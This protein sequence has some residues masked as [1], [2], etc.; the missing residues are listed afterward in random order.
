ML[1]LDRAKKIDMDNRV[2]T[3][4]TIA[5][6]V[7]LVFIYII[8]LIVTFHSNLN[9]S[10]KPEYFIRFFNIMLSFLAIISCLLCYDS[11]KKEELFIISLMYMI[12]LI[13]ILLGVFDNLTLENTII[14]MKGYIAIST[15]IMRIIII[16]IAAFP[17][18]K[19]RNFIMENKIQII[20]FIVLTALCFGYMERESIIF[21]MNKDTDFFR[22]Y[23]FLLILIYTISSFIFFRK[24][25][26]ENDYT[27]SVIG[28]SILMLWIK[29]IYAIVGSD[30][31]IMDIK[32][33]SISIT[34]MSFI[35]LIVGLFLELILTIKKNREL[36]EEIKVFYN[37]VEENKHSCIYISDLNG[38]VLYSNKK[39]KKYLFKDEDIKIDI[40][41][42]KVKYE[43]NT[44]N[45]DIFKSIKKNIA[46]R[47]C[48]NGKIELKSGS[49][50]ID[51]S[52][53]TI[54]DSRLTNLNKKSGTAKFVVTFTDV[55][56]KDRME[57]YKIEYEKMKD[58]EKVKSEFFANISHELRTPLNIFYSTV[59]L[60]DIKLNNNEEEFRKSYDK[61]RSSLR[62]NCQRM[63]RLINN[64]VDITK[65]DVGY[66]K[67]NIV[68]CDIVKLVEAI[69]MSVIIYARQKDINIIFDTDVEE[70]IIKC[71]PEMIERA[72]LNLLSNSIKFTKP[73][74]N[75]F[76]SIYVNKE[77]VQIIFE[78]D[79]VGIPIHMQDLVFERFV[80]A[81]K[82]LNRMNEGSGIGLSIVKSIIELNEGEIYLESDG[83]NGTEFEILLPNKKLLGDDLI[84]KEIEYTIDMQKI[85]LEL[86]DI[87]ELH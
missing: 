50:T 35:V 87:Y 43:I 36:K 55:T 48:W 78:D 17:I 39:M 29:A 47:G 22:E 6:S 63:L 67:P 19:I 31:P 28:A 77:W 38:N 82:S 30:K 53:Q 8:S 73:N 5:I 65:I 12:F 10:I 79:G 7:C 52:V 16:L 74:G 2:A 85:E 86:S 15:S 45:P 71:D 13:D 26:K 46:D 70:L 14:S 56:E 75:I 27:Y 1:E 4:L 61:Y 18:K 54:I 69:T 76:V 72:V 64:I 23:N 25:I 40:L 33:I 83:E 68:N 11:T 9:F 41:T 58:H 59:Q 51:C 57:K 62:L 37:L 66:T 42:E 81:D 24:S 20:I 49:T 84:D 60:L 80:Q 21:P 44:I 32:Y 3:K 34:Y